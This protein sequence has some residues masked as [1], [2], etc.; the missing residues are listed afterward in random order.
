MSTTPYK[1]L[2][3]LPKTYWSIEGFPRIVQPLLASTE[4]QYL[5]SMSNIIPPP[6]DVKQA[7]DSI[8]N[9]KAGSLPHLSASYSSI[10]H[11]LITKN[12]IKVIFN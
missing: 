4:S 5:A 6:S 2:L 1:T 7:H 10:I 3:L 11:P 9:K 8:I 12:L